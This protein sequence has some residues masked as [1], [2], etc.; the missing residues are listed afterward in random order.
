MPRNLRGPAVDHTQA[1]PRENQVSNPWAGPRTD[2]SSPESS[3]G[4]SGTFL[5]NPAHTCRNLPGEDQ[6]PTPSSLCSI[7]SP[8]LMPPECPLQPHRET[9]GPELV[10]DWSQPEH[11]LCTHD[12]PHTVFCLVLFVPFFHFTVVQLLQTTL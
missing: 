10:S 8:P 4:P 7:F 3:Q 5:V 12:M 2:Y 1:V 11:L 6:A 9:T